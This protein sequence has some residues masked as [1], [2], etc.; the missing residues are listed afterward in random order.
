MPSSDRGRFSA[1]RKRE[2]VLR[3]LRGEDLDL[4]SREIGVTGAT[5]AKWRDAFLES[6]LT[7]L[8]SKPTDERDE[9]I[10][11]LQRKLGQV[12]MEN[13]LLEKKIERMENGLPF[14]PRRSRR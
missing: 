12:T 13:E 7:G 2:A 3:L 10:E 14:V 6:G 8:S 11:N 1:K 4:V 9:Q 5:L